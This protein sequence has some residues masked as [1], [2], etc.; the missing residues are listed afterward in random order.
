MVEIIFRVAQL[1]REASDGWIDAADLGRRGKP[2]AFLG[3]LRCRYRSLCRLIIVLREIEGCL[4]SGLILYLGQSELRLDAIHFCPGLVERG[5]MP[6]PAGR[7]PV[8]GR[9]RALFIAA[10]LIAM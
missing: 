3:S 1:G 5:L 10:P 8:Q 4:R 2:C 9:T 7:A 6:L